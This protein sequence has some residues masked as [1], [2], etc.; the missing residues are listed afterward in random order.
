[1]NVPTTTTQSQTVTTISPL[2]D[3]VRFEHLQRVGQML[4][5]SVLFPEHL[6]KGDRQ[7]AAA[8]GALVMNMA[9]RLN[10][11]PLTVAQNIYFVGGKPGWSTTY[12]IAKANQHG[13]FK[14]PINWKITGEGD[15]LSVTAYATL[16]ESGEKVSHTVDMK[17][18]KA[19]NWTSNKKYQS[20]PQVMLRYRS[21][22]ALIRFYCPE[23]MVGLPTQIEVETGGEE[24]RDVT[25]RQSWQPEPNLADE[26]ENEASDAE[27]VDNEPE[28]TATEKVAAEKAHEESEDTKPEPE[29]KQAVDRQPDQ[30][31][32]Q[33]LFNMIVQ[34][35]QD[36]PNVQSVIDLYGPQIEQ[37]K[38]AAPDLHKKLEAEF[39]AFSEENAD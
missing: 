29:K 34:D 6:R 24:M 31:Q 18:A 17:M 7:Q 25:P 39:A 23:V 13:V 27:I 22:A 1:M 15:N 2:M 32:F 21:A 10:E 5:A 16:A 4:A 20:I 9:M 14:G 38:T 26:V 8:N 28:Q 11:D 36:A 37:M 19:E 35:L 3:P 30:A 12:M 33:G